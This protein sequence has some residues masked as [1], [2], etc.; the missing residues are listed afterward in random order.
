[1]KKRRVSQEDE[2]D[3]LE[4]IAAAANIL[5]Q[6]K[7]LKKFQ[8]PVRKPLDVIKNPSS[9]LPPNSQGGNVADGY[10]TVLW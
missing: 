6:A 7:P 10:F 3:K 2:E 9:A 4:A 8:S 1:M 5:K